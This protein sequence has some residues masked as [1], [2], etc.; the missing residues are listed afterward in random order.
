MRIPR[1]VV[2][3]LCCSASI[4]LALGLAAGCGSSPGY[5]DP[6][7]GTNPTGDGSTTAD[8]PVFGTTDAP[9]PCQGLEC[10]RVACPNGGTTSASGTIYDP[11]GTRPLYNVVVYVP[12]APLAPFTP[13]VTCDQCGTLS[14]KPIAT[15]LSDTSGKFKIDNLPVGKDIPLVMQVGKWRRKITLPEVKACVD[16]P[17]AD[18]NQT[19]LPRTQSEGDMPLI[20]LTTGEFDAP[21]CLLR[22]VGIADSEFTTASGSGRVH[23]YASSQGADRFDSSL[24]GGAAFT[25]A[26]PFWSDLNNLK[27][28]D[29]VMLSCEG[30]H[31]ENDKPQVAMQAMFDY[32]SAGGRIFASHWQHWWFEGGPQPFPTVATFNHQPDIGHVE[33]DIDMS[34]PKGKALAEWLMT[35]NGSTTL[36]KVT[37]TG[38]QH[39]VDD[40]LAPAQRWIYS[41]SPKSTQYLSFNT[42]IGAAADKQCGRVVST[43][44]HVA[45][46]DVSTTST[47]FPTGCTAA[48][49]APEGKVL[50]FMLFDLTS[51]V[52]KDSDPPKPPPPR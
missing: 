8:A 21:E 19:R 16:T 2:L 48:D 12:N 22:K 23:L 9:P 33:A 13:G 44:L 6:P 30:G 27:K 26:T 52:Q 45:S 38:A 29:V 11:A 43:D 7:P 25:G 4:A 17:I 34:F 10:Q 3:G 50:E 36:G 51:C 31:H 46:G 41:A 15:A 49:L 28:Y 35:V 24:N 37:I 39:T 32:A 20:A 1:W 14:G 18:K 5:S 40:T 47:P 42:P